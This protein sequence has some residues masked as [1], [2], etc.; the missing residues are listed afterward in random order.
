MKTDETKTKSKPD[1]SPSAGETALMYPLCDY[2]DC[3]CHELDSDGCGCADDLPCVCCSEF[4][5]P[6]EASQ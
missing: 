1:D 4:Y 3:E 2:R 5:S 6:R